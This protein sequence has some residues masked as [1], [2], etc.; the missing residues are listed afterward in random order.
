MRT[1]IRTENA[2]QPI[3]PYVQAIKTESNFIFLS[4]QIPL[5]ARGYLAAEDMEGQTKQVFENIKAVL[6]EAGCSL[7]NVV[8][9]TVFLKDMNDFATM[10]AVYGEYFSENPPARAA[11]E[12]ARL[13]KDVLVEIECIALV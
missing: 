3:G 1:E 5:D 8:K 10:N 7:K 12:V 2:P 13:P 9:T 4:G 6:A 11:I